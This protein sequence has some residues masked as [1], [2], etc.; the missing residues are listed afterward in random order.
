MKRQTNAKPFTGLIKKAKYYIEHRYNMLLLTGS[1]HW[2]LN[3]ARQ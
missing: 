3:R 2:K 1:K